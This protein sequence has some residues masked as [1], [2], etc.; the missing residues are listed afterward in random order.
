MRSLGSDHDAL[1][2]GMQKRQPTRKMALGRFRRN[3]LFYHRYWTKFFS[4]T[5]PDLT[6][7]ATFI[8][9]EKKTLTLT[10]LVREIVRSRLQLGPQ[11]TGDASV[12]VREET[13]S[14]RFW[15]PTKRWNLGD[16][17][18]FPVPGPDSE[19]RYLPRIGTIIHLEDE[20]T[21][22]SIDGVSRPRTFQKPEPADSSESLVS[23]SDLDALF[24]SEK[25]DLQID[26]VLWRYGDTLAEQVLAGLL[27]DDRFLYLHHVWYLR[28]L[29]PLLSETQIVNL[30]RGLFAHSDEPVPF[31]SLVP[32]VDPP[33]SAGPIERFGLLR[34]LLAHPA[35][36]QKVS[37]N[38]EPLWTLSG[39]PPGRWIA[40]HA[41]YDPETFE[42]LC[43]PWEAIN[44][45]AAQRLWDCHLFR[46]VVTGESV[47]E[48]AH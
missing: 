14:V 39:P 32:L 44:P 4:V 42:V 2:P 5:R 31:D 8:G 11:L 3:K 16:R 41:A 9:S 46:A 38:P 24:E 48:N 10:A 36:F 6:R 40:R 27:M 22:V 28:T 26:Y 15:D 13:P 1:Q 18:I 21:L 7:L 45:E 20:T 17:A 30:A 35:L 37:A 19:R 43:A 47:S 12:R 34:T 25:E 23:A 29:S 33:L